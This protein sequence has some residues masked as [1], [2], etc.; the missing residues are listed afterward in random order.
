M[1][2]VGRRVNLHT[3]LTKSVV[4]KLVLL[5][6]KF[7]DYYEVLLVCERTESSSFNTASAFLSLFVTFPFQDESELPVFRQV[8]RTPKTPHQDHII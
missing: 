5:I 4:L 3:L 1:F 6:S 2:L 7:V 8:H